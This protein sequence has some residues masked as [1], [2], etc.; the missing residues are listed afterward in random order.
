VNEFGRWLQRRMDERDLNQ[1]GLAIKLG[2]RHST[3]NRWLNGSA[4]PRPKYLRA[5]TRVLDIPPEEVYE[6]LG[7]LQKKRGAQDPRLDEDSREALH[8]LQELSGEGRAAALG[9]LR[10]IREMEQRYVVRSN[11]K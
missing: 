10:A 4:R 2:V 1:P 9:M 3:V 11:G 6:A 7:D 8:L 5:L